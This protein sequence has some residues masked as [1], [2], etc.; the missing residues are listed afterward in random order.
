MFTLR[1]LTV[2]GVS[3]PTSGT[4]KPSFIDEIV[5]KLSTELDRTQKFLVA[6]DP[7]SK[8]CQF[9]KKSSHAIRIAIL[10]EPPVVLPLNGNPDNFK[11]FDIVFELGR[12]PE[13]VH[14]SHIA[15]PWPQDMTL[16]R[17]FYNSNR[18]NEYVIVCGNKFSFVPGELYSLRRKLIMHLG[19]KIELYGTGWKDKRLKVL[20]RVAKSA[21]FA[22]SNQRFSFSGKS[23]LMLSTPGNFRGQPKDKLLELQKY[24]R[25]L[26]VENWNLYYTEKLF[27]ALKAG[28]LPIYVG[29]PLEKIGVPEGFAIQGPNNYE[30]LLR[31]MS[32]SNQQLDE[33]KR[34]EIDAWLS[35]IQNPHNS[36]NV[37]TSLLEHVMNF[38]VRTND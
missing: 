38:C 12:L 7:S 2:T 28:C 30:D 26:V 9:A 16:S 25:T 22:I 10:M 19:E 29:P 3:A 5:S 23:S 20:T 24:D 36:K 27:D 1:N 33:I 21:L 4:Q 32:S 18:K 13:N 8:D 35:S 37:T 11:N 14:K 17:D 31:V 6:F 15:L 34:K